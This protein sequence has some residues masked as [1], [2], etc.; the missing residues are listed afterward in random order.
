MMALPV[1]VIGSNFSTYWQ[2]NKRRKIQRSSS[3][4]K[5]SM[6]MPDM[7][8]DIS[9]DDVKSGKEPMIVTHR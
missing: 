2:H 9:L 3:G 5:S 6:D 4:K 8:D 7:K 1:A